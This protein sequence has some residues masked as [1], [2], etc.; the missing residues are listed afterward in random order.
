MSEAKLQKIAQVDL[1]PSTE[2]CAC[3]ADCFVDSCYPKIHVFVSLQFSRWDA[4]IGFHPW[5]LTTEICN[6]P[7]GNRAFE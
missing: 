4:T 3:F 7:G 2:K 1:D 5:D 6:T